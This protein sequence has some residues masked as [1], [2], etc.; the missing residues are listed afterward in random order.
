MLLPVTV[1]SS[2]GMWAL[3]PNAI[4]S[5]VYVLTVLALLIRPRDIPDKSHV[6]VQYSMRLAST[7]RDTSSRGFCQSCRNRLSTRS[8][9]PGVV[10]ET[11]QEPVNLL[12]F[13][14]GSDPEDEYKI[15]SSDWNGGKG[16]SQSFIEE[17]GSQ[18]HS[19]TSMR[20]VTNH[21]RGPGDIVIQVDRLEETFVSPSDQSQQALR[22][23][24]QNVMGGDFSSAPE[25]EST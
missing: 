2:K 18:L 10:S 6:E 3:V 23:P 9:Q 11:T 7:S 25:V 14:K 8:V 4:I 17:G 24:R 13:L 21:D 22:R 1:L 12:S 20:P 5:K 19:A 16:Y 15:N